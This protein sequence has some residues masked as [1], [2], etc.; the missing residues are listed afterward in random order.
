V[1]EL[2][3]ARPLSNHLTVQRKRVSSTLYV[4]EFGHL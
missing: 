1:L 4:E 2:E 3:G